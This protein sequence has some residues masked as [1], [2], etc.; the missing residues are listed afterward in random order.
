M[1]H[2]VGRY[3]PT[4][5]VDEKYTV[6]LLVLLKLPGVEWVSCG[7]NVKNAYMLYFTTSRVVISVT[8]YKFQPKMRT[9]LCYN[10]YRL[11]THGYLLDILALFHAIM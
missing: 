1:K 10:F 2:L 3:L 8:V 7:K 9:Y 5:L 11:F 4:R 6:P